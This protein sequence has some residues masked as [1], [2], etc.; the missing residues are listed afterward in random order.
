MLVYRFKALYGR[1]EDRWS[2]LHEMMWSFT[3]PRAKRISGF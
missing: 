1:Y 2:F 3:S